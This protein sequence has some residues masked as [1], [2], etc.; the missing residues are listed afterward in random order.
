[1][2]TEQVKLAK[3]FKQGE[4]QDWCCVKFTCCPHSDPSGVTGCSGIWFAC[5][6]HWDRPL[7]GLQ[8][9]VDAHSRSGASPEA[10]PPSGWVLHNS[11][12]RAVDI[13]GQDK[14]GT[15]AL[16]SP[17]CNTARIQLREEEATCSYRR[18]RTMCQEMGAFGKISLKY[19][20]SHC[21]RNSKQMTDSCVSPTPRSQFSR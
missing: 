20:S 16:Q 10:T 13:Q 8:P 18:E 4:E 5:L 9:R 15:Q 21:F 11:S 1:M 6:P 19:Q 17:H 12:A 2:K 14:V 3:R 7:R